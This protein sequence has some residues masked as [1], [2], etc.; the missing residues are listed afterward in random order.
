VAWHAPP[1]SW[2]GLGAVPGSRAKS[3]HAAWCSYYHDSLPPSLLGPLHRPRGYL[4]VPR[5]G[6]WWG[7][8]PRHPTGVEPAAVC[9]T[10]VCAMT[11]TQSHNTECCCCLGSKLLKHSLNMHKLGWGCA[12]G[13]NGILIPLPNSICS[14]VREKFWRNNSHSQKRRKTSMLD[15]L[16]LS[17]KTRTNDSDWK[18]LK[19]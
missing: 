7:W 10:C 18:Q 14:G 5:G 4:L 11:P 6:K 8:V 16:Q 12:R 15:K 9:A 13:R 1:A 2:V 17:H 19:S 3:N